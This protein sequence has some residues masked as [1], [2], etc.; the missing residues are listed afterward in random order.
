M[1][2][3]LSNFTDTNSTFHIQ[4]SIRPHKVNC[5]WSTCWSVI[6]LHDLC[7]Q[8]YSVFTMQLKCLHNLH[9]VTSPSRRLCFGSLEKLDAQVSAFGTDPTFHDGLY[10]ISYHFGFHKIKNKTTTTTRRKKHNTKKSWW[11]NL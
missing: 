2:V 10:T 5:V 1:A 11:P 6:Y 4:C 3:P 8:M 9:S 7:N